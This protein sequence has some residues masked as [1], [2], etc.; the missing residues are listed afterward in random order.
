[1]ITLKIAFGSF[2]PFAV[3]VDGQPLIYCKTYQAAAG[4]I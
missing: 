4:L 1:M 2:Y 3:C